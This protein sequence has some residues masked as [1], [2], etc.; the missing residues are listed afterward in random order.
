MAKL[1]V[2][3][4]YE[5]AEDVSIGITEETT[6]WILMKFYSGRRAKSRIASITMAAGDACRMIQVIDVLLHG[7]TTVMAGEMAE[8][9][10]AVLGSGIMAPTP[11][12]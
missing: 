10:A 4:E 1:A 11:R 8:K 3:E 7:P 12:V 5:I 9:E 2:G 6:P